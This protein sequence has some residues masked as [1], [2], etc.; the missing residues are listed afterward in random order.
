MAKKKAK[1][2]K[3][4]KVTKKVEPKAKPKPRVKKDPSEEQ[5]LR[6]FYCP[7]VGKEYEEAMSDKEYESLPP[8]RCRNNGIPIRPSTESS[9]L[10]ESEQ[11]SLE[12]GYD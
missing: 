6:I 12:A 2:A 10:L 1:A 4:K 11:R 7:F 5:L 8:L 3:P 9:A